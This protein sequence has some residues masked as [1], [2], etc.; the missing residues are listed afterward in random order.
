MSI[1]WFFVLIF[2][3]YKNTRTFEKVTINFNK[4]Q[5]IL[6]FKCA[7]PLGIAQMVA[8]LNANIPRYI[9]EHF[10]GVKELGIYAAI[11]YIVVAGHNLIIAISNSILPIL[12]ISF[13]EG[14]IKSFKRIQLFVVSL[15]T[16]LGCCALSII[17]FMGN[18]IL[19][20]IYG[21]EFSSYSQEFL[22]ITL[23]G[24]ILYIS[25]FIETGL[26]AT[27][28]F[29]VQPYINLTTFLLVII[30]SFYFIPLYGIIGAG[31]VLLFA[32]IVQL[33]IRSML[34]GRFLKNTKTISLQN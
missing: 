16:I 32:E 34:L 14:N 1:I 28:K 29:R 12:S 33:T 18:E 30:G 26:S 8:S 3:D 17:Y 4:K 15:T 25:K 6:L 21:S 13:K 10:Q 23:F 11:I 2:F 31:Y 5:Q 19:Y 22:L 7:F 24:I 9:I 20:I 27:R